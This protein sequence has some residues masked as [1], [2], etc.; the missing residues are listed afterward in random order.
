M[1]TSTNHPKLNVVTGATGLLGSHVAEQLRAAGER[2]RALVRPG[3]DTSF[4]HKLGVEIVPGDLA[5]AGSLRQLADG[6]DVVY[7]CAA[8]VSDWGPWKVFEQEAVTATRN[9]VEACRAGKVGRLL[10]VSSISVYG[11]MRLKP[12]EEIT[13][14]TPLG[15]KF[16]L[17]DYYPQAKYLA[18]KIAW[19]FG[20]DVTVVRPSWIYGPRDRMTIP[21]LVPALTNGKALI[22]GSGQNLLNVIYAGDVAAGCI[23]AANNPQARG[24]AYNLSS[25]GE[26][27]QIDMV[28][29][30]TDVL[31]LPRVRKRVPYWLALR[32]AFL[33]E[34]VARLLRRAKP[35]TITRRAVFLI[36][37]PAQYS[38]AKARTQLGW[39]PQVGIQ[40]GVRRSLEWYFASRNEKMPA[41]G[42][43]KEAAQSVT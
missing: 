4:L 34:A 38:T 23:L 1:N 15:R 5:D 13:E 17:W 2:V 21:R 27:T 32:F 18:E 43:L 29:A 41:L 28:N 3:G 33:Q 22:V 8:R 30:L 9:I 10:H 42:E 37:R 7:H 31:H 14:E 35:P 19:E 26:V 36:G 25:H 39:Q 20:P 24:Q 40:E 6:A 11:H 12:G 16:W